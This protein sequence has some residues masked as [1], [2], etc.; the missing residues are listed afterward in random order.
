MRHASLSGILIEHGR[1]HR[2]IDSTY[3]Q[4]VIQQMRRYLMLPAGCRR[5]NQNPVPTVND[6]PRREG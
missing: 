2:A 1:E 3:I 4:V 5:Q 6:P